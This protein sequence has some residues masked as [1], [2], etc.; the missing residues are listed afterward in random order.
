MDKRQQHIKKSS[1]CRC[2]E[3]APA[4]GKHRASEEIDFLQKII[5]TES[6]QFLSW[7]RN[8]WSWTEWNF[9]FCRIWERRDLRASMHSCWLSEWFQIHAISKWL[10]IQFWMFQQQWQTGRR[11]KYS[12]WCDQSWHHSNHEKFLQITSVRQQFPIQFPIS[13]EL[14]ISAVHSLFLANWI[15]LCGSDTKEAASTTS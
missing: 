5:T 9:A 4:S 11:D 1:I 10:W 7:D 2:Q 3:N 13:R 14:K 12:S 8:H 15:T 6:D